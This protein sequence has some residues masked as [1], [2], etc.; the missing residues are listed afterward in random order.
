MPTWEA[1]PAVAGS[2]PL[3]YAARDGG[4]HL[5][6]QLLARN[7]Q[8]LNAKARV[9]VLFSFNSTSGSGFFHLQFLGVFDSVENI[10]R[11]CKAISSRI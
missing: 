9:C 5:F 3:H 2:T 11:L 8:L 10:V 7:S 1:S 6:A 4:T